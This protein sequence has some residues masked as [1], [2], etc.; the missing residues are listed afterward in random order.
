MARPMSTEHATGTSVCPPFAWIVICDALGSL[1]YCSFSGFCSDR[2]SMATSFFHPCSFSAYRGGFGQ[3]VLKP[4][5][6]HVSMR[7]D[8]GDAHAQIRHRTRS[9]GSRKTIRR[10]TAGNFPKVDERSEGNGSRDPVAP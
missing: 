4:P 5:N 3:A 9:P 1:R 2:R 8:Q 10:A 6:L 7:A